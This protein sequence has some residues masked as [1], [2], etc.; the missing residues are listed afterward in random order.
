MQ[1]AI[2][3]VI[4]HKWRGIKSRVYLFYM[5]LTLP[6]DLLLLATCYLRHLTTLVSSSICNLGPMHGLIMMIIASRL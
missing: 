5:S 4:A 2:I 1:L 3:A 6:P